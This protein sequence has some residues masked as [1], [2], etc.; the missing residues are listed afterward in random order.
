MKANWSAGLRLRLAAGN[1]RIE[2]AAIPPIQVTVAS[3][4][5]QKTSDKAQ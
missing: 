4:C 5:S 2:M 3:R 1:T